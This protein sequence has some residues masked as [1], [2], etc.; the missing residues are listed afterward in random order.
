MEGGS[1]GDENKCLDS[2]CSSAVKSIRFANHSDSKSRSADCFSQDALLVLFCL[3]YGTGF[4]VA[5][6]SLEL[7]V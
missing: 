6:A 4:Q 7:T 5:Q 2:V 3:F 1:H